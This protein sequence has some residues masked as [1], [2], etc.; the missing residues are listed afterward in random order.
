MVVF[1]LL[2]GLASFGNVNR[3]LVQELLN[4][5]PEK[6]KAFQARFVGHVFPGENY[7]INVWKEGKTLVFEG[8]VAER[9][10]KCLVGSIELKEEGKL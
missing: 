10:T 2:K 7:T 3:A 4:N 1:M 6:V 9:E 8:I 5:E